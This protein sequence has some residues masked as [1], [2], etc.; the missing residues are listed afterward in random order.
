M[1]NNKVSSMIC[2]HLNNP[3]N[4]KQRIKKL[5]RIK[6]NYLGLNSVEYADYYQMF[7]G[8]PLRRIFAFAYSK[9]TKKEKSKL[10]VMEVARYYNHTQYLSRN[11]YY[12]P[13]AGKR[14]DFFNK[15]S[16]EKWPLKKNSP[17]NYWKFWPTQSLQNKKQFLKENN[18]LYTG[19]N[20]NIDMYFDEYLT[21]YL[22]NPKIELLSK[23]NLGY[24][25]KYLRYL[26]TSKKALHEIFKIKQECTPL[27]R[28]EFF[29]YKA[30]MVCRKTGATD[31]ETIRAHM[32]VDESRQSYLNYFKYSSEGPN[33]DILKIL[34]EKNTYK[35][36]AKQFKKKNF[37]TSDYLDYLKELVTLGAINDSKAVYPKAFQKAHKEAGEKIKIAKSEELINGFK[38]AYK[39]HLKYA[40]ENNS[41][42]IRPVEFPKELY[43]ESDKLGHCVRTYDKNVAAGTTEILFIRKIE[44]P[45]K[46]FFTLELKK[47]K[48][49]Q[50]RGK[51]NK[52]PNESIKA[53]VSEWADKYHINYTGEQ[54]YYAYY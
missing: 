36:I 22:E 2:G 39:K 40:Y 33:E 15:N 42:L 50:V 21:V 18:L 47:K 49:I 8:K 10:Y 1:E 35:Y 19:W 20:T 38:K 11:L 54:E 29:N 27:I 46:P 7:D 53:F 4:L 30:L 13:M 34:N 24:W 25:V 6:G 48:I 43:D 26:D 44:M 5:G 9:E 23:A 41:Y 32:S 52:D 51:N 28:N 16:F 45:D 17:C 12:Y 31:M 3:K 14:V 37:R